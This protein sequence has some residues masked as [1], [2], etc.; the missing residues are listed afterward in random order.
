[1]LIPCYRSHLT[2]AISVRPVRCRT[3]YRRAV[4]M[5][6]MPPL[7]YRPLYRS[8]LRIAS[9]LL[10]THARS[11]SGRPAGGRANG[12]CA[13]L[14][15]GDS[16]ARRR[17]RQ[18]SHG[19]S[20]LVASIIRSSSRSQVSSIHHACTNGRQAVRRRAMPNAWGRCACDLRAAC[21]RAILRAVGR[22]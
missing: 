22:A 10:R 12:P 21:G 20:C 9:V 7:A 8:A 3:R 18:R 16:D 15:W 17:A 19:R 1:V 11:Q 2:R 4:R 13:C 6:G 5:R 14:P